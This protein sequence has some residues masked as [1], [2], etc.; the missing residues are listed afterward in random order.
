MNFAEREGNIYG[1]ANAS[2]AVAFDYSANHLYVESFNY[3]KKS[4]DTALEGIRCIAENT[5]MNLP[6]HFYVY[7]NITC[8]Y[9]LHIS[10]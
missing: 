3:G 8:C 10:L 4:L 5:K 2:N 6:L 1:I 7:G 9:D